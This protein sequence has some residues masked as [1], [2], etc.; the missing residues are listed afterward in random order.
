M[1]DELLAREPY[2]VTAVALANKMA[3]I[4]W[5]LM[6]RNDVFWLKLAALA[7][8]HKDVGIAEIGEMLR[9]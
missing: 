7:T 1:G 6:T 8:A 2:Q 3:H 9:N 4:V 5:A